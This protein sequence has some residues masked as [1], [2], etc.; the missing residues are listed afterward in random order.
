MSWENIHEH[1]DEH[2]TP[3][4]L[5]SEEI[6]YII[7]HHP[8]PRS[9]DDFSRD[10]AREQSMLQLAKQLENLKVC[11][12]SI[13]EICQSIIDTHQDSLIEPGTAIGINISESVGA[14]STQ[15]TLNTFHHAGSSATLG[16]EPMEDL[17]YCRAMPSN[18][19]VSVY[20]E[21][22][23]L[24]YSEARAK[25]HQLVGVTVS[26]L[27]KDFDIIQIDDFLD[28]IE[29]KNQ[30]WSKL[31]YSKN[32]ESIK[33]SRHVLR[34]YMNASEMYK[35][36][37]TTVEVAEVIGSDVPS[38]SVF[39][40]P[41]PNNM[42]VIDIFANS[43]NLIGVLENNHILYVEDYVDQVFFNSIVLER[44]ESVYVKGISGITD[45][46][47]KTVKITSVIAKAVNQGEECLFYYNMR[48]MMESG[49]SSDNIALMLKTCGVGVIAI[50]D[51]YIVATLPEDR[52]I[53]EAGNPCISYNGDYYERNDNVIEHDG[54][55]YI[56][57][58]N[59]GIVIG[60]TE[61][62][63][64]QVV[65]WNGSYYAKTN[66]KIKE[67][68]GL[69]YITRVIDEDTNA[70]Q[71]EVQLASEALLKEHIDDPTVLAQNMEQ[72]VTQTDIMK[73]SEFHYVEAIGSN[74]LEIL[75]IPGVDQ[76]LTKSNNMREL[77][78]IFGIEAC[79]LFIVRT[80]KML[81]GE[82]VHSMHIIALS[83][84]FTNRGDPFGANFTG[85]SRQAAGPLSSA[86]MEKAVSIIASEASV[87]SSENVHSIS[88]S[89]MQ[90]NRVPLG[91]G[92]SNIGMNLEVDGEM[93]KVLNEE[94]FRLSFG[95]Q[96][97]NI[98][99][100]GGT[101][102]ED[103]E[104]GVMRENFEDV[105]ELDPSTPNI[106][107]NIGRPVPESIASV[108]VV[109]TPDRVALSVGLVVRPVYDPAP[110]AE[111]EVLMKLLGEKSIIGVGNT[112]NK[113]KT[114]TTVVVKSDADLSADMDI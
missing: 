76:T 65:E 86:T 32:E 19:Y 7:S 67:V 80:C 81:F 64:V 84:F 98:P 36:R 111:S 89:I 24:T 110:M 43:P 11:P 107:A 77:R 14:S 66:G 18:P 94:L 53:S 38:N 113:L 103:D 20:F 101:V 70:H 16:L 30:W 10:Y 21:N 27:I 15:N 73:A 49:V 35:H 114:R 85:V 78:A 100:V 56:P 17:I 12:S 59:G 82:S 34:L 2:D 102:D 39:V 51:E 62:S 5:T 1:Y 55:Y 63:L 42:A 95:D 46:H 106:D 41:S 22:K 31:T 69:D 61:Y 79:R 25:R 4:K 9:A 105:D 6:E 91:S 108:T 23:H 58:E 47:V 26:Q 8:Y 97:F 45:M 88:V 83:D 3:R 112:A 92:Y 50:E 99:A 71:K 40:S 52:Y 44:L 37:I 74:L 33:E 109:P 93:K 96:D 48:A 29:K 54:D 57:T 104:T 60:D 28:E 72:Q 90:G 75:T 87:G 68:N 13:P